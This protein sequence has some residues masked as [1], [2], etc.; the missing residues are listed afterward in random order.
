[1]QG[2]SIAKNMA[3]TYA[4]LGAMG[5]YFSDFTVRRVPFSLGSSSVITGSGM[6]VRK[7]LYEYCL[8]QDMQV[9]KTRGVVV[10]VDKALQLELVNKAHRIAYAREAI[11]VDEKVAS[12]DQVSRQRSRWLNSYFRHSF[13]VIKTFFAGLAKMDW[14]MLWFAVTTLM[15]PLFI[16][17]F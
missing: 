5:E 4:A 9:L 11:V 2:R 3:S 15:P 7:A 10:G 16:L 13:E 8:S 6:S 17:V 14:N 12:F 1:V